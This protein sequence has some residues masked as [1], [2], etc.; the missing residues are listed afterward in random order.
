MNTVNNPTTPADLPHDIYSTATESPDFASR[1]MRDRV[2]DVKVRCSEMYD[3]ACEKVAEGA[4]TTDEAVHNH[5]YS[6]IGMALG[7]GVLIGVLIGRP[8][9][10]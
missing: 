4:R 6:A 5:P 8:R 7:V 2:A 10:G 9:S 3:E 1:S